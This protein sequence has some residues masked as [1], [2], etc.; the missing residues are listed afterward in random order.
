MLGNCWPLSLNVIIFQIQLL[1]N[2]VTS[3]HNTEKMALVGLVV[4][5]RGKQ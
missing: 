2:K 5:I 3:K 4:T 1:K